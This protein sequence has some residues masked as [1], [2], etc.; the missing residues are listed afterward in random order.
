MTLHVQLA[1]QDPQTGEHQSVSA[2]P[3]IA[4]GRDW[5]QLPE[6]H[7]GQSV[8]RILLTG[9]KV[10]RFH[11]LIQTVQDQAQI[12]DQN[13]S[14]GVQVNTVPQS[15]C[16]LKTGDLI[17]IGSYQITVTLTS[18]RPARQDSVIQIPDPVVSDLVGSEETTNPFPPPC[19]QARQ[20]DVQALYAT[21]LPIEEI[22]YVAVGAGLGSFVWVDCLRLSGVQTHQIRA[23]GLESQPYARYQ[24]LCLNS[25]IP[26]H[27]R[28][29]SNSD[30][31]P[32]NIWGWPS[33]A[34]R[35]AWASLKKGQLGAASQRL[36]QV[37]AEPTFAET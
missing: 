11:A 26:P 3:P 24:R 36:W 10:S 18:A 12:L 35:E 32:D 37:F 28:L 6:H 20:I 13:S 16:L 23:L 8:T 19:F 27:E 33:Y 14:N 5:N 31:C 15:V 7:Q 21:R 29:R 25:Q 17:Q 34:L 30:S 4:F 22:E 9:S 1:W 2:T